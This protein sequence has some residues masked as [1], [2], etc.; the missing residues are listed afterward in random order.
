[1]TGFDQAYELGIYNRWNSPWRVKFFVEGHSSGIT[2]LRGGDRPIKFEFQNEKDDYSDPYRPSRV[3]ITLAVTENFLFTDLFTQDQMSC[4]VEIYQDGESD[5]DLYWRGWVDPSQYKEPYDVPP[6]YLEI[7]CIDG[8]TLLRSIKYAEEEDSSGNLTYYTGRK[9]ES[10]I[11]YDIL[12]KIGYTEFKEFINLY[13][14]AMTISA[15]DSPADQ[16]LIDVSLFKDLYCDDVLKKILN[17]HLACIR[18][19]AGVFCIYRPKDLVK[20]TV[21]GRHFTNGSTKTAVVHYPTQ[22]ISRTATHPSA[23]RQIPGGMRMQQTVGRP[24]VHQDFGNKESWIS[25]YKLHAETYNPTTHV[26]QGWDE[27][28]GDY[29][30]PV[31]DYVGGEVEGA[32]L[33][34]NSGAHSFFAEFGDLGFYTAFDLG[35]LEFEYGFYSEHAVDYGPL[36]APLL[37]ITSGTGGITLTLTA[38]DETTAHW[39]YGGSALGILTTIEPGWSG[40]KT[41]RIQ[42]TGFG[43]G[44]EFKAQLLYNLYSDYYTAIKNV[45]FYATSFS[46]RKK[47]LQRTL[48]QRVIVRGRNEG[49]SIILRDKYYTVKYKEAAENSV[50]AT[51]IPV[52]GF[53]SGEELD[54][55]FVLGDVI[56]ESSPAEDSDVGI[57]NIIEQFAG[58]L[59]VYRPETLIAAAIRFAAENGDVWL[60]AVVLTVEEDSSGVTFLIFTAAVAGVNFSAATAITNISG[61]LSG[62]V[63]TLQANVVAVNDKKRV[64]LI[65]TDGSVNIHVNGT[66]YALSFTTSLPNTAEQFFIDYEDALFAGGFI[67]THPVGT[68]YI[69]VEA[70]SSLLNITVVNV[71]GTLDGSVSTLQTYTAAVARIDVIELSGLSGSATIACNGDSAVM[72]ISVSVTPTTAWIEGDGSSGEA[73]Q[74]LHIMGDELAEQY[75][76]VKDFLDVP[77][78]ENEDAPSSLDIMGSFRDDYDKINGIARAF[79]VNRGSFDVR[80]CEWK[81]DLVEIIGAEEIPDEESYSG[82]SGS[83]LP[84]N[85]LLNDDGSPILNDD[86]GYIYTS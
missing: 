74:L 17:K 40:W 63:A 79:V 83:G 72:D 56:K 85:I 71:S 37:K 13:D 70:T 49:F 48:R 14:I 21:Y 50:E 36:I 22:Y 80:N 39:T 25:N 53:T 57:T 38:I 9:L 12:Q 23:F 34:T 62:S 10:D 32:I 30:V 27:T 58:A 75:S 67:V 1:M 60:T 8:L 20:A 7:V 35:V 28:G 29:V 26:W 11:I 45:R 33:I 15:S 52:T 46:I 4:Y 59:A 65:G 61:D 16:T 24:R 69:D 51:Y 55:D 18:Q 66:P 76:R 19:K 43:W 86:G 6:Y 2:T 54:F 3:I 81:L 31:G 84:S 73:K 44:N 77:I 82:E 5:S 78:L 42:F 64:T 68:A 47:Q 41:F